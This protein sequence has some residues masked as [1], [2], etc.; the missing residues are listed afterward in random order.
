MHGDLPSMLV[1]GIA[2]LLLQ[3]LHPAVMSGVAQHSRYREDPFGRLSRTASF[4]GTTT[5]G[6]ADD[7]RA[8]LQH[9]AGVHG[10]VQ[11]ATSDG[12]P[13]RADDPRLLEWVHVSE[14]AMF[15]AGVS[16]YGPR[17]F[18]SDVY[19]RYVE[20][21]AV[22]ARDLGVPTP[23]RNVVEL[24][25][26]LEG[27]RPELRLIDEGRE[28]RDF[29]LRGVP[30]SP[31]RRLAYSTLMAAAVGILPSWARRQLEITT[32]PLSD[33]LVVRPV[34]TVLCSSIRLAVSA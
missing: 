29:V 32:V 12:T 13:Y 25:D 33:A 31:P 26:R 1:G 19:D 21:M 22:V 8:A 4:V 3:I 16:A 10:R 24:Q 23:P 15:A 20:E 6:S 18:D 2:S 34:A 30:A 27:F 5:F 7:A 28:A 17:R 14:L 11:G 9:V